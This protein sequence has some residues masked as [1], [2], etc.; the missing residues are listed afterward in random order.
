M[1]STSRRRFLQTAS[2]ASLAVAGGAL[3]SLARAQ[4]PVA[5]RLSSSMPANQNAAHYV[6]YQY[7]AE[8]LKASVGEQI[9]ID[10][11]P[12]NQL[13]KESDV[14]QQVKVGA[15]DMM[16]TGSSIWA[17]VLPELG[18]LDLGYVFDNFD[19][20]GR[21]MD[22]SVGQSFDSLLQKRAGCSVITWGY[23]FGGR[24]VFTK[25]PAHS[26]AEIKG[27]KLRVLPTPAFMD[28]FKLMGAVPTP[29]PIGELYMAAQ[30]GVVDGFEHDCAT[31]L[32][33]KYDE[34]VKS[35]WQTQHVFSPLVVVMGR[36]SLDK[37]PANL[38]PA[39]Q[40]AAQDATAKQRT[41]AV[42]TAARAEQELK[43]RGMT[44]FP[45]SP[46]DRETARHEMQTQLYAN[47][48]KQ[49][50]ATAPLF[51]AIAAARG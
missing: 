33:S 27:V 2:A 24:N 35:C 46:A 3:P 12:N 41:V 16:V 39:F 50:P 20:V 18:M 36:R 25:K 29:I 23:S 34:V 15:V 21:A 26:L 13:G 40:K 37:I 48:A 47:F 49:Y 4:A 9:R 5:L 22:G 28:T 7:L 31:V 10:Y 6:W 42:Q 43:Q 14:V 17:T 8:N 32:A 45:M 44:F 11:F 38:R 51:P 19:H 1:Q 30:T